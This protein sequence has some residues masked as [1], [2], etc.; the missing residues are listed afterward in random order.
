M[1]LAVDFSGIWIRPFAV[2]GDKF[3]VVLVMGWKHAQVICGEACNLKGL[4]LTPLCCPFSEQRRCL[5]TV[6]PKVRCLFEH[7]ASAGGGCSKA[8][9]PGQDSWAVQTP[10]DHCRGSDGREMRRHRFHFLT[11]LLWARILLPA[12]D[13]GSEC[14][15]ALA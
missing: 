10:R 8:G 3:C 7:P 2:S 5:R 4:T 13:A 9:S 12:A 14:G 1:S 11:D 15:V 6:M